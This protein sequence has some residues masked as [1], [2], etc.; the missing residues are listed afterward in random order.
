M[1]LYYQEGN[2]YA[3]KAPDV[4]LVKG[5]DGA[6]ERDSFKTWVEGTVPAVVIEVSSKST[7][8]EDMVIKAS[9]YARLGVKEYFIFDPLQE[10]LS[11]QLI[12]FRLIDD[13]YV[14]L[15]AGEDGGI[16]CEE[17][18]VRLIP[19]GRFLFVTDLRTGKDIPALEREY[20]ALAAIESELQ[21]MT[22]RAEQEAQRAAQ[23]EAENQR[24]RALLEQLQSSDK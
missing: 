20:E 5:V 11:S 7:W 13:E 23:T 12:G 18:E 3:N 6:Y 2:K 16:D 17:M 22:R 1:F 14:Q 21:D 4:M 19:N 15:P 9:L 10:Y 24:L 8:I